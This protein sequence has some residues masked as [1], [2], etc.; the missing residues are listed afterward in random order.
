MKFL[1]RQE[2]AE[3]GTKEGMEDKKERKMHGRNLRSE[4][5]RMGGERGGRRGK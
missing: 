1:G 4:R 3:E 5:Q 2:G